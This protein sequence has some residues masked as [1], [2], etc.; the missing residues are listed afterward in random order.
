MKKFLVVMVVVLGLFLV[1]CDDGNGNTVNFNGTWTKDNIQFIIGGNEYT[2]VVNTNNHKKGNFTHTA[3]T[4]TLT[5]TH[6]WQSNN[7]L[8]GSWN[9]VTVT[10]HLSG[11]TLTISGGTGNNEVY[12]GVWTR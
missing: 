9:P 10:Y 3:T 5:D 7:W 2:I 1:S 12:N 11:D 4:L 8:S 6:E